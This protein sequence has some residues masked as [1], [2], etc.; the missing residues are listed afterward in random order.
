MIVRAGLRLLHAK[1][2][3]HV[4]N[5]VTPCK[6][7]FCVCTFEEFCIAAANV[8]TLRASEILFTQHGTI[9]LPDLESDTQWLNPAFLPHFWENYTSLKILVSLSIVTLCRS[10]WYWWHFPRKP[11]WW[12]INYNAQSHWTEKHVTY[13]LPFP[14]SIVPDSMWLNPCHRLGLSW[15]AANALLRNSRGR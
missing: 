14:G 9:Q 3:K 4:R 12:S 2:W 11:K 10:R 13:Y 7:Q 8:S 1:V 5:G 6:L 15:D